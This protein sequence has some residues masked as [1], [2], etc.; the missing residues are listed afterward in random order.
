M[1]CCEK[2][3]EEK[4]KMKGE[5]ENKNKKNHLHM[6]SNRAYMHDYCSS[7]VCLHIFASTDVSVFLVKMCK[8]EHFLYFANFCNH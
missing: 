2:K 5:R 8:I 7:F 3:T 6:N 1:V 4:S